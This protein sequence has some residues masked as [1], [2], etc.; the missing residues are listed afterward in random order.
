[1]IGNIECPICGKNDWSSGILASDKPNRPV[2]FW[3]GGPLAPVT[4]EI[5]ALVCRNCGYA[6][7]QAKRPD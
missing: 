4:L 7:L 1:M 6:I 3:P 2:R 5:G